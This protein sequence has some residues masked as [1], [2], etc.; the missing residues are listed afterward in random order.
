MVEAEE[1]ADGEETEMKILS[2]L[3]K[4][5]SWLIT[6]RM[7]EAIKGKERRP[8]ESRLQN[9]GGVGGLEIVSKGVMGL[10]EGQQRGGEEAKK[11]RAGEEGLQLKVG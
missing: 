1:Q 2:P 5:G 11:I 3:L 4:M 10:G 9:G 7:K 6:M 8:G